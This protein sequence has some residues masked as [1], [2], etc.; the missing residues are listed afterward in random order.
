MNVHSFPPIV[1]A[2]SRYLIL[3][4][5]P[6]VASLRAQRYYWNER[7]FMW[8]ILYGLFSPG[9]APSERYEDRVA[10]ALNH[11]VALWDVIE[12]C[13]RPG[14][15]DSN[16]KQVIPNDIPGLL[17]RFPK[18]G[19]LVCNGTKSHSE[20]N[21]HFGTDPEVVKR[22]IIR[23]PSTSPIPTRDYRGLDDRLAAWRAL[24]EV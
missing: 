2:D 6:G 10:F 3:G 1:D 18:I 14:S 13:E 5:M 16:I 15:L 22:R 4:S 21:K 9:S 7:N 12:S 23:M 11:G 19:I 8:R 17:A 24:L 20:L